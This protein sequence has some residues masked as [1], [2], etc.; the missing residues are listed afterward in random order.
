MGTTLL[1]SNFMN[2]FKRVELENK[3]QVI[4]MITLSLFSNQT[5]LETFIKLLGM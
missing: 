3:D 4:N 5:R 2:V 1:A